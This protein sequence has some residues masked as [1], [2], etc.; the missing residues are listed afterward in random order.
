MSVLFSQLQTITT[1]LTSSSQALR[2]H[3]EL[4]NPFNDKTL[5]LCEIRYNLIAK[6]IFFC[7][8]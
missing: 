5:I 4:Q 8:K 2:S 6:L 3:I 7:R 1:N